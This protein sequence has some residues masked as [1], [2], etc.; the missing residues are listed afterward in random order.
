MTPTAGSFDCSTALLLEDATRRWS[1]EKF[2]FAV[3]FPAWREGLAV[4]VQLGFGSTVSELDSC[5]GVQENSQTLQ[6]GGNGQPVIVFKLGPPPTDLAVG[7]TCSGFWQQGTKVTVKY[8]GSDCR[9]PPPPA[10]PDDRYWVDCYRDAAFMSP[11][12]GNGKLPPPPPEF[13]QT[14]L[15]FYEYHLTKADTHTATAQIRA[16]KWRRGTQ[17]QLIFKKPVSILSVFG[18]SLEVDSVEEMAGDAS[19]PSLV[20]TFVLGHATDAVCRYQQMRPGGRRLAGHAEDGRRQEEQ[21]EDGRRREG[22]AED[23]RRQE[24]HAEDGRRRE[25]HAEDGRRREGHAEEGRRLDGHAEDDWRRRRLDWSRGQALAKDYDTTPLRIY[26]TTQIDDGAGPTIS[27]REPLIGSTSPARTGPAAS[28]T[29][30]RPPLA[31][32]VA[33]TDDEDDDAHCARYLID[34]LSAYEPPYLLPLSPLL[35]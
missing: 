22:H 8:D 15:G 4:T 26:H 6:S 32:E 10:Y 5:W 34:C 3:R 20:H 19:K 16:D 29:F 9:P 28:D 11:A 12:W 27:F 23:G 30:N 31:D 35:A 25:G 24:G 14:R 13:V 33:R 7:C 18:A 21:A 17:V 2:Q 1:D